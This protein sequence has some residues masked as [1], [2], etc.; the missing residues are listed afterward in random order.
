[1]ENLVAKFLALKL[2]MSLLPSHSPKIFI[3]NPVL[4]RASAGSSSSPLQTPPCFVDGAKHCWPDHVELRFAYPSTDYPKLIKKAPV[5]LVYNDINDPII[6][7]PDEQ[8]EE[9]EVTTIGSSHGWV[10]SLM[11]GVGILRLHD[12]LNPVASDANPKCISLPPLVS[13]PHCQTQIVTNVSLSS[14]SPEEEDC[15]VAVKFMRPQLSYCRPSAQGNSKWFNIRIA[16][17]CIM[18]SLQR[19]AHTQ[20]SGVAIS[21]PSRADRSR[22]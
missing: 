13:L 3:R 12:D 10:A 22:T 17:P 20:V 21:L 5:E 19:R 6:P 15:V 14:L 1:M 4:V 11:H 16:N 8:F 9:G 7:W 2:I 18:G